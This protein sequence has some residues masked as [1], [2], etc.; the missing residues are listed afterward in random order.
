MTVEKNEKK[1]DRRK[2]SSGFSSLMFIN[3][4]P[5]LVGLEQGRGSLSHPVRLG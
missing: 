3:D 5:N 2:I 1:K 4:V